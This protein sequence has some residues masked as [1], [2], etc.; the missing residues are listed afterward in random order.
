MTNKDKFLK[1]KQTSAIRKNMSCKVF[2]LKI[3][4]NKL[5]RHQRDFLYRNFIEAKWFYNHILS[6]SDIFNIDCKFKTVNVLNKERQPEVRNLIVLSAQCKQ[7]LVKRIQTSI[8]SLSTKKKK[9]NSKEVGR[10]RFKSEVN[11]I[12]LKQYGI[13]Y[14]INFN[15]KTVKLSGLKSPLKVKGLEQFVNFHDIEFANATL[16]KRQ[17]DFFI[18][19][20]TF[21]PKKPNTNT[22]KT[23][24]GLDFGIETDLTLSNGL[25][26]FTK[27][28][29]SKNI[30]RSQRRL[31][32]KVKG[33]NNYFKEKIKLQ[34]KYQKQNNKKKEAINKVVS[35]LKNN[36]D[37]IAI[38]NENIK[39]WHSG[40][41]GRQVQE[42]IL[43]GIISEVKKLPQ[44]H[45]VDRYFPSTKLCKNCGAL[46]SLTL[47][48]RTY[49]CDCGAKET[50][51]DVHAAENILIE[52]ML[53]E[54]LI[55]LKDKVPM[56]RRFMPVEF[57]V[58]SIETL[59]NFFKGTIVNL[60]FESG[61]YNFL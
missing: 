53:N 36:Y 23:S 17:N 42:S 49:K 41:F 13:S 21:Q 7:E 4:S 45:L 44:T 38:Q 34:K 32:R 10:L 46:N 54:G 30:K 11:S 9:G 29:V 26:F 55:D 47:A 60:N 51:R 1:G 15:Q 35:Y 14:K 5:N 8:K 58:T 27:I 16:I 12:P 57:D 50:D 3:S 6:Q 52:G 24:V 43:G 20:T 25:K 56:E 40:L 59:K 31:S 48:D 39:G 61:R 2:E 19:V 37:F 18:K 28:K 33:S 22:L